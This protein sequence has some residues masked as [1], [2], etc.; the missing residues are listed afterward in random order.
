M[1]QL[2]LASL[3]AALLAVALLGGC[4]YEPA[5]PYT[6]G[7]TGY[8]GYGYAE[9]TPSYAYYPTWEYG[10]DNDYW[11]GYYGGGYYRA[12]HYY[13]GWHR[14]YG[15]GDHDHRHAGRA[16]YRNHGNYHHAYAR[17]VEHGAMRRSGAH[18]GGRYGGHRDHRHDH[19]IFRR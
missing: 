1:S 3:G 17:H 8:G 13:H 5:E 6:Y 16:G 12:P 11:P 10:D 19:D 4:A 14:R 15:Y 9:A 2:S 7:Y 18:H